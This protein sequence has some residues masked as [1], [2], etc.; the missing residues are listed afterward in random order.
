MEGMN[1]LLPAFAAIFLPIILGLISR[2]GNF[3][4]PSHR[5]NIQQFAVRVTIPFMVFESLRNMDV[6]TAGQFLPMSLGLFLFMGLGWLFFWAALS[7]LTPRSQWFNK[8]KA[9]LLLMAFAGNIGYICW[10]L[11]EM[12]IGAEGLQRGIFYTSFYWPAM[13]IYSFLTVWVLKLTKQHR[14][15]KKNLLYNVVPLLF[16][17][18]L[19]LIVGIMEIPL[20]LWLTQ[21]T[22]SFGSM[23]VPLVLFCMGLSIS[24]KGSLKSARA[25]LP[26]LAIRLVIWLG[27]TALM[28]QLPWFD[29]VSRQVLMINA[30]APLGVNPIV[31]SDMFGLDSEFV[32]NSITISTVIFLLFLPFLFLLRG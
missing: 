6:K 2:N 24:I 22:G 26:Y 1:A 21:F 7:L 5:A 25:L 12:L 4:D 11:Q 28:L 32:A 8:Y 27:A 9:E 15:D 10:K 17:I 3:I 31:V 19:G 23:A 20:P 14:L 29:T 16:M 18:A 13:L 30:L